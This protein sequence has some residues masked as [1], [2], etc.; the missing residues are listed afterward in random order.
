MLQQCEWAGC[1][2]KYQGTFQL[3]SSLQLFFI[4]PGRRAG[5]SKQHGTHTHQLKTLFPH[6]A[7][8]TA[9]Q[10]C[11]WRVLAVVGCLQ[12]LPWGRWS[13]QLIWYSGTSREGCAEQIAAFMDHT[14]QCRSVFLMAASAARSPQPVLQF[15]RSLQ[16]FTCCFEDLFS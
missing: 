12:S 7:A 15:P 2:L 6:P 8:F 13:L 3:S 4:V 16:D 5:G 14:F 11:C 1:C 10:R 9:M